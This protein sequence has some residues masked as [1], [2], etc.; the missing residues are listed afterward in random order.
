MRARTKRT[1]VGV[2]AAE[3]ARV[4]CSWKKWWWGIWCRVGM[5][6]RESEAAKDSY[7]ASL[8]RLKHGGF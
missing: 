7:V 6:V 3:T 5:G 1:K 8:Y 4:R 2:D